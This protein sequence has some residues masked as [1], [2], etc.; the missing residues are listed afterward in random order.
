[1]RDVLDN[2][3]TIDYRIQEEE[4][5]KQLAKKT[6]AELEKKERKEAEDNFK[7]KF[8]KLKNDPI[9]VEHILGKFNNVTSTTNDRINN[10]KL[11]IEEIKRLSTAGIIPQGHELYIGDKYA[12]RL[13][14]AASGLYRE[15]GDI[16]LKTDISSKYRTNE[17]QTYLNELATG[18]RGK[19]VSEGTEKNNKMRIQKLNLIECLAS[20]VY[21]D[22]SSTIKTTY[23]IKTKA[24][25]PKPANDEEN[26]QYNKKDYERVKEGIVNKLREN[27]AK[28]TDAEV[29]M[30]LA[31][32]FMLRISTIR[33]LPVEQ[34]TP[35]KATIEVYDN[36][37]KS[38]Q[39]FLATASYTE[40]E[41]YETKEILSLIVQRAKLRYS[42]KRNT[43]GTIPVIIASE[44][45]LNRQYHK[46]NKRYGVKVNWKGN[47]H[48]LR[49]MGAQNRYDEVRTVLED[50]NETKAKDKRLD[51]SEMQMKALV[52]LNY[53]LG[54]SAIHINTT[55]GYVKNIW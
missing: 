44:S 33:A 1:M 24:K 28:V 21:A 13:K 51:D 3:D 42:D 19:Q 39:N 46:I 14:Q 45:F 16:N 4:E 36:Q 12:S 41:S 11:M 7:L 38:K 54:H 50:A 10:S 47:Y 25:Y 49:H 5:K 30:I 35:A 53:A 48:A 2:I 22:Y 31:G 23:E 6:K 52:E 18:N 40:P 20:N 55:M 9:V 8:E 27:P 26:R 29:A 34:I 32:D 37:N 17:A 15:L 43:D